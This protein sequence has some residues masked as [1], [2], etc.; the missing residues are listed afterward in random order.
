MKLEYSGMIT[1]YSD[2]RVRVA[3]AVVEIN[4]KKLWKRE[5]AIYGYDEDNK[6]TVHDENNIT[7]TMFDYDGNE[8]ETTFNVG[9]ISVNQ[10]I[11]DIE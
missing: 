2:Q 8:Y 4:S 10:N 7:L 5:P 1:P 3:N 9:T 6:L 11:K